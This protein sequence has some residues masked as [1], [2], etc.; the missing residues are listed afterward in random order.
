MCFYRVLEK[1]REKEQEKEWAKQCPYFVEKD[2]NDKS[3]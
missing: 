3:V 1:K 2:E